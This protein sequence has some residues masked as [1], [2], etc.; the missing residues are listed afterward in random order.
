[1]VL[2]IGHFDDDLLQPVIEWMRHKL[3]KKL[4]KLTNNMSNGS[5]GGK[6][7]FIENTNTNS[8]SEASSTDQRF[9]SKKNSFMNN[10]N[11][12]NNGRSNE[13]HLDME[14]QEQTAK[15]KKSIFMYKSQ[16]NVSVESLGSNPDQFDPFER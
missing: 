2:P 6:R 10:N 16:G 4:A 14:A 1:M 11:N 7:P 9:D 12:N 13:D 15:R 3:S 8:T 5:G